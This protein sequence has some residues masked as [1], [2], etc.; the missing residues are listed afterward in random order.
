MKPIQDKYPIFEANQ[1]LTSRHLNEVFDYLNEQE[2][3]T[4][5]NLIGIGIEC[6]LEI[7]LEI[8]GSDTTIHISQ[9][10]GVSS[11]GYILIEPQD[12]ALVSYQKYT[13][14]LDIDYPQFKYESAGNSVQYQLWELFPAGE[15]NTI[16]LG[17]VNNFLDDKVVILFLELKNEGLR[18][19]SPNN[20]D[21]K[22]NE[23]TATVKP[24]LI[25]KVNLEK[26]IAKANKLGA[27][28]TATD[29]E[30]V[31]L[32]RLNL[33]DLHLP[34]YNVPNTAPVSSN[35][36]LAGFHD[37][38]QKNKLATNTGEALTATYKAFMPLVVDTFPNDPFA[39]FD[40]NFGFLDGIPTST[41]QV[42][43]LPY[44][45]DFFD[46]LIQAYDEFRWKA[47]SLMCACCPPEDLFPRHLM[48]GLPDPGSVANP[49]I[50]R[51][52]FLSSPAIKG[53]EERK[54]EVLQLFSRLVEMINNFTNNPTPPE[55][56]N[57][58]VARKL[59]P[60]R[61]T[62]SKLADVPISQKA[63]PYYYL[64]NG[65]PPLFQLWNVEKTRRNRANQNLS[66]RSDEYIPKA[67]IFVTK[68]LNYDL[69]P[70]NFL[71]IEGHLGKKVVDV[72]DTLAAF[73]TD[74]RLPVE[75]I[76]LRTGEFDAR[77]TVDL[78]KEVCH[79]EDL[80][81]I[82]DAF[83]DQFISSLGKTLASFYTRK[84][85]KVVSLADDFKASLIHSINPDFKVEPSTFGALLETHF[86]SL[87]KSKTTKTAVL[88]RVAAVN[89]KD[90]FLS[91]SAVIQATASYAEVL[92]DICNYLKDRGLSDFDLTA[93]R[94]LFNRLETLNAQFKTQI[95]TAD[96]EW[97]SLFN[98]LEA[99]RYANEMEAF[100]SIGEEY[101][102]RLIEIK[103][104]LFLSNFLLK[105]PGIQHK[106]GVPMG[107]TFILVYHDDPT[108]LRLLP[109]LAEGIDSLKSNFTKA[110]FATD[111]SEAITKAFERLQVKGDATQ[112]DP[113]IQL[114][115]S[116]MSKQI[117][118]PD[119]EIGKGSRLKTAEKIITETVNEFADGTVIADF[120]LP[121]ICCSDCSPIQYIMAKDPL[122]FSVNIGC[123]NSDKGAKVIVTPWGGVAPYKIKINN[124]DFKDQAAELLLTTGKYTFILRDSEGTLSNPQQIEIAAPLTLGNPN[125]DCGD[126]NQYVAVIEISGG[127]P[128]YTT[129]K[130]KILNDKT[131]FGESL[132]GNTDIEIIITDSRKC[133]ASVVLNHSCIPDLAFSVNI[134]CTSSKN[135]ALVEILPTGG[136]EPYEFQIG[137]NDF[138]PLNETVT[139]P[140]GV[141][142]VTVR[143]S[144]DTKVKQDITVPITLALSIVEFINNPRSKGYQARIKVS[145]GT[146]PYKSATG[147]QTSEN[148]FITDPIPD[149]ES[150]RFEVADSKTCKVGIELQNFSFTVNIECP[151][152]DDQAKV[153]V[154]P[155][156]GTAPYKLKINDEEF[157]DLDND[158]ILSS[159]KYVLILSDSKDLLSAVQQIEVPA[160]LS[161]EEPGFDCVGDNNEYVASFLIS[162]GTPPYTAKPGNINGSNYFSNPLPGNTDIEIIISDSRNC[163]AS[164][165]LNH[166]CVSDLTFSTIIGCTS[167][168][169]EAMVEI[170]PS[171]GVV[172]Y[173]F[174]VGT[175]PVTTLSEAIALSSGNHLIT[176]FD[177]VGTSVSNEVTIPAMLE[178]NI[179]EF[180]CDKETKTYLARIQV[181]GGT[182]PYKSKDG[183]KTSENEFVTAPIPD[184]ELINFEVF[185]GKKCSS[186]IEVQHV[187]DEPCK[188]PCEGQSQKCAYRLW[189]Q[190]PTDGTE[191]IEYNQLEN[192]RFR[193]N[194]K[195]IILPDSNQILQ[196]PVDELNKNF[197]NAMTQSITKLNES[198]QKALIDGFGDVG[199][200]RLAITYEPSEVDPFGILW[201]EYFVCESFN[202][203]FEY[204]VQKPEQNLQLRFRYT[205]EPDEPGNP[206]NGTISTN[207]GMNNQ[208][209]VV[210][211][212][213]CRERNQCAG[214]DFANLCL[215][216]IGNP[217]FSIRQTDNGFF[218]L[219]SI[220]KNK[221]LVAWVWDI[222]NT[223]AQE[224]FYTGE[225]LDA[226]IPKPTGIVRLTTINSKG[227]FAFIDKD[228]KQ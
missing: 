45:F 110:G 162:G 184:G 177:S 202:L 21:D 87:S 102:K 183:E 37:V 190:P 44:Y 195:P 113:D 25:E 38:F 50:Y 180:I 47:A 70:Y 16:F 154:T 90:A 86:A 36:V 19:C 82:Y 93:F 12:L 6:G 91:E 133:T 94:D 41:S 129:N 143:D 103:K 132:P 139:L 223:T 104:R 112:V 222:I 136:V 135:E 108:E 83:R 220:T 194:G 69:E 14:P 78:S 55:F 34:R 77:M 27:D 182:T 167:A 191:Y 60:V 66:F 52:D 164:V 173:Q 224:P 221:T 22:G 156:N 84:I 214:S 128:P 150:G 62:P 74:Y 126:G 179:A 4:R 30:S 99:V 106:A 170:I 219:T 123:T 8:N 186:S 40:Q 209:N 227:C 144:A 140:A 32:S 48:L 105:N 181:S 117:V 65:V 196:I 116:E 73:K 7:R 149:G 171:G 5:A 176:L 1:V 188:L 192:L 24:L 10:G 193:F 174:Q 15:P 120:Y 11:A 61:I 76:A 63:I 42:R 226:I 199:K 2:R 138:S 228:F 57:L 215:E 28:Y 178:L 142:T 64:Q 207:F 155:I 100:R 217:D 212:F 124:E 53:C 101:R 39:D 152:A 163:T 187:C 26:I 96:T 67:P 211:A 225:S 95:N 218:N 98:L 134:G 205:N 35:D 119:F 198:I 56:A 46:D 125:F 97:N 189:L 172:P 58:E 185:D 54:A 157:K 210:P 204:M 146:A 33:P 197:V 145:G 13:L 23:V 203:E 49:G 59:M 29:L 115:L 166:S 17:K 159:G 92:L 107:G 114:I 168:N 20:C 3:L 51:H 109:N 79:F 148:E 153:V 141:S 131:F 127:T 137:Q 161:I 147:K 72:M 201:I 71:R 31:L 165:T 88:K 118:K 160:H 151:N 122:N 85:T 75:I 121:Y 200:N 130:G 175:D 206:F 80:E 81:A 213:D 18:N 9:G 89:I 111:S 208:Q 169:N 68:A 158:L 216:K 43:F